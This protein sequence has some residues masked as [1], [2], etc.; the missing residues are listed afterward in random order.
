VHPPRRPRDARGP[1]AASVATSA[2][3]LTHLAGGGALPG[4]L[5]I[6]VPWA[7]SLAVCTALAGR[8]L[9]FWRTAVSVALSQVLFHTLFVLGTPTA[10]GA[11][12]GQHLGHGVPGGP[13]AESPAGLADLLQAGPAM[14]FWHAVAAAATVAA[15][16]GGERVLLRLREL[17]GRLAQWVRRRF[18]TPAGLVLPY[19]VVRVPAPGWFSDSFSARLER[20][21]L[22]RRGPPRAYAT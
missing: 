8:R 15:L 9:S 4:W 19:P 17:A 18:E 3:L 21:P 6:A 16:Y 20:S 2:A 10:A 11:S 22:W 5:G 7:L 1:V 12:A 14:W 13:P